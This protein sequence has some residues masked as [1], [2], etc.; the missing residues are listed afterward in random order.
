MIVIA[1]TKIPEPSPAA[2]DFYFPFPIEIVEAA[3]DGGILGLYIGGAS[4]GILGAWMAKSANG[5][6]AT[7][8][9]GKEAIQDNGAVAV[10]VNAPAAPSKRERPAQPGSP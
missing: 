10:G 5:R 7:E 8:D 6:K 4:G 9:G 1:T 3:I 2:H